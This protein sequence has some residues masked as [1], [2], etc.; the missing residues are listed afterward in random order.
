MVAVPG[1]GG[2]ATFS[3]RLDQQGNSARGVA[4]CRRFAELTEQRHHA[5]RNREGG[6][7]A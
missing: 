7:A 3:P 5:F 4:C 2:L 1:V 6:A